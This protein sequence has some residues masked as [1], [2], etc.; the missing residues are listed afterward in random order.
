VAVHIFACPR[1]ELELPPEA[2]SPPP[3]VR[4]ALVVMEVRSIPA[5]VVPDLDAFFRFVESV[6][7]LR[8]KQLRTAAA[9]AAGVSPEESAARLLGLGI[10]PT[11]RAETLRLGDWERVFRAFAA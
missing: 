6:F 1:L 4:S 11:R 8:R 10:E 5:V 7:Q 9:R 2:F 3:A